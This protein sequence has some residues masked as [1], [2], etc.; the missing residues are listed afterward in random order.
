MRADGLPEE[1]SGRSGQAR[2]ARL[3]GSILLGWGLVVAVTMARHEFWRDEIR[4]LSLAMDANSLPDLK[5]LLENE[6]HPMLWYVLLYA[7]YGL[8]GS[9][10]V[11]PALSVLVCGA[12]VL[13]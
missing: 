2:Q 7:A 9:K 1:Q 10:L 5:A 4:A 3:C 12:A 13:I 8:T 6:G 11:L